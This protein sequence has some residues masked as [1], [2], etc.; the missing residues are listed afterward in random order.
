MA[1]VASQVLPNHKT[2]SASRSQENMLVGKQNYAAEIISSPRTLPL[3]ECRKA[4]KRIRNGV[5][6]AWTTHSQHRLGHMKG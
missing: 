5:G 4:G 6:E 2:K 1:R 3:R